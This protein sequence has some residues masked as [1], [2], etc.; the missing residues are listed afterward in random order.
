MLIVEDEPLIAVLLEDM[1]AGLGVEV[2]DR[3][4]DLDKAQE[5]AKRDGFDAAILDINL[6]GRMCYPAAEELTR[7]GVPIVMVSGYAGDGMPP[8]LANAVVVPK[9][10]QSEQIAAALARV[11]GLRPTDES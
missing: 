4:A 11:L 7:R 10:Y 6:H 8:T 1:M 2:T 3:A 5:A 9:P